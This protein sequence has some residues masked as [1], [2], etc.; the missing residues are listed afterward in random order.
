PGCRPVPTC[1]LRCGSR[2][3]R[4]TRAPG[5]PPRS[6]G[7]PQQLFAPPPP[8]CE[9]AVEVVAPIPQRRPGPV[10][11][12]GHRAFAELRQLRIHVDP[13]RDLPQVVG[14]IVLADE[15]PGPPPRRHR[16]P[17]PLNRTPPR[18]RNCNSECTDLGVL[19]SSKSGLNNRS[20]PGPPGRLASHSTKS[21]EAWR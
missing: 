15:E 11:G 8:V 18:W 6:L 13:G 16:C 19:S 17:F 5:S 3:A 7:R 12:L 21:T 1:T 2:A 14:G 9:P 10:A 20:W 4:S